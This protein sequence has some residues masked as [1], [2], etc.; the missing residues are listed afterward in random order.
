MTA[1]LPLWDSLR[2]A[3]GSSRV[4]QNQGGGSRL[5]AAASQA[6]RDQARLDASRDT[7]ASEVIAFQVV[8]QRARFAGLASDGEPVVAPL[9]PRELEVLGLVAAGRTDG[10]IADEL[11]ISKKTASVHVANIKGKLGAA[12]R[13]EIVL[14]ARRLGLVDHVA[15]DATTL[16]PDAQPARSAVI[17]PFKGLA[18]YER[19]DA[20]YFFGRERVVAELVARLAS[21]T[22]VAVTGSS[23]SGKSSV[24]RAGLVPAVRAGVLPGSDGWHAV[25]IR[26]GPHPATELARAVAGELE[27][28]ADRAA[29]DPL[30]ALDTLAPG[31][32]MV[33]VVDQLEEAFTLCPDAADRARFFD[34]IAALAGDGRRRALVAVAIRGDFYGRCAEHPAL[35]ALVGGGTVLLGPMAADELARAIELPAR[36]AGLRLDPDL[37][38]V[39][40]GDVL[41]QPGGLPLLS[42]TLL[43]LWQRRDGRALRTDTYRAIGGITGAVARLAEGAI[44]RLSPDEQAVAKALLLRLSSTTESGAVVRRRATLDELGASSPAVM[45]VLDVLTERRLVAVDEGQVDLA[46]EALLRDWPRMRRWLEEDLEGRRTRERLA[47]AARDWEAAE[48]DPSELYRGQRLR[49]PRSGPR[50]TARISTSWSASSSS[51]AAPPPTRS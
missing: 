18:S 29:G 15:G 24:L 19:A 35:A 39:L 10:E 5:S 42:A 3:E 40:V 47:R 30:D 46:H 45:H 8:R 14:V 21:S 23:G 16:A 7:V 51:T 44:D 4:V 27:T 12:S 6:A 32:R 9:S 36:A 26:P 37:P 43:D 33:V 11:F 2:G 38:S 49:P 50:R 22:F 13:I 41:A 17:C 25:I 20:A 48:R 1:R 34:A 28:P 31:T